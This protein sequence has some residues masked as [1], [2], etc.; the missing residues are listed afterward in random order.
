MLVPN[1]LIKGTRGAGKIPPEADLVFDVE[2]LENS[3]IKKR[4]NIEL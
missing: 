4:G 2:L 3:S 1:I